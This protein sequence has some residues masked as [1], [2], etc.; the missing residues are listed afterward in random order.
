MRKTHTRY[1]KDQ[2]HDVVTIDKLIPNSR[3]LF[4]SSDNMTRAVKISYQENL[5]CGLNWQIRE[6]LQ[7]Q[8]ILMTCFLNVENRSIK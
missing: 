5:I 4:V 8:G 2:A 7:S 3:H 1:Q 6:S